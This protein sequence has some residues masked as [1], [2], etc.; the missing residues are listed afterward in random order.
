M[1]REFMKKFLYMC[2]ICCVMGCL[3]GCKSQVGV[4]N[5]SSIPEEEKNISTKEPEI[6]KEPEATKEHET[7]KK[8]EITSELIETETPAY[9]SFLK[10]D[11]GEY[12]VVFEINGYLY[13]YNLDMAIDDMELV[14]EPSVEAVGYGSQKVKVTPVCITDGHKKEELGG[15]RGY[16][17]D[18]KSDTWVEPKCFM[19]N[20]ICGKVISVDECGITIRI[21]EEIDRDTYMEFINLSE[22]ESYYEISEDI[23]YV[24]RDINMRSTQVTFERFLEHLK[25]N[26]DIIYYLYERDGKIVQ[27]WEP[28]IP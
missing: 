2:I 28:Y 6:T 5:Q 11:F 18:V 9:Y 16:Q 14:V 13:R 25:R 23:E 8:P 22:E 1:R 24:V 10:G 26:K 15:M 12:N 4:E 17:F 7:T 27:I 20:K 19:E 3:S 21:A